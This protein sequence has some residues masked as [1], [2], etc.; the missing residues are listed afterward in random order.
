MGAVVVGLLLVLSVGCMKEEEFKTTV[1][2][3]AL[4]TSER[5]EKSPLS[6]IVV[7][8]F[9]VDTSLYAPANY[10]DALAGRLT[11]KQRPDEQLEAKRRGEL[12]HVEGHGSTMKLDASGIESLYLLVVDT[13]EKLYGY[14]Q[15]ALVENLPHLYVSV[16]FDPHKGGRSYKSG[17]WMMFD[18]FYLPEFTCT[19]KAILQM[20][21]GGNTSSVKGSKL[22][23]FKMSEEGEESGYDVE[24]WADEWYIAS[25]EEAEVGRLRRTADNT[26]RDF[27]FSVS[28]KS[29]G[30]AS[31][32]LQPADYLLLLFN[33]AQ[34]SY[35]LRPLSRKEIYNSEVEIPELPD[36]P[37]KPIEPTSATRVT[38]EELLPQDKHLTICFA[39]WQSL[40]PYEEDNGWTIWYEVA[41]EEIPDE[42]PD[43]EGDEGSDEVTN[44]K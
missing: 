36:Y 42:T 16:I 18:D 38:D 7:Y 32:E 33:R 8:G 25:F 14:T 15:V 10:A 2:V 29:S 31:I 37:V 22:F 40:S 21:E 43:E 5:G 41:S 13:N 19:V 28:A 3:K 44:E 26:P 23:V 17:K 20:N 12:C 4:T 24:A 6:D 9:A 35:G 27:S 39:S 34:R 1:V 11:H 30:E